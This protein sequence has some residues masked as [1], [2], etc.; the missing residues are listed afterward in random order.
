MRKVNWS[1]LKAI[2]FDMDGLMIDTEK[3]YQV[4]WE[5]ALQYY[6]YQPSKQLLLDLRSLSRDLA[7]KLLQ[8]HFGTGL[9]YTKIRNK[10]VELMNAYIDEHGVEKKEGLDE[11]LAYC[12]EKKLRM[13]VATATDYE[14]ANQYMTQLKIRDKFE[15]IV[16]G[17]MVK[18]GK[19]A[20]DIY[21]K[22]VELLGVLPEECIALEDSP[23]GG[24]AAS[25]AGCNVIMVPED[26]NEDLGSDIGFIASCDNLIDVI[27]YLDKSSKL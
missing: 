10:R 16:C 27:S 5:R 13:A 7:A 19:P 24:R 4:F 18:H 25:A 15:V 21:L 1:I 2:I 6:D 22:V 9:D 11:L 20:P 26:K 14:R 8:D 23:N 17:P 3:L 12:S